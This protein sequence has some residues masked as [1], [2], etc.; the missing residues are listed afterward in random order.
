MNLVKEILY[1]NNGKRTTMPNLAIGNQQIAE[2]AA[3][4][5]AGLLPPGIDAIANGLP[6][7]GPT[8]WTNTAW[9]TRPGP[10]K[11]WVAQSTVDVIVP[12]RSPDGSYV[13]KPFTPG[14]GLDFS[15]WSRAQ[16]DF[17]NS[18]YG[19]FFPALPV[20]VKIFFNSDQAR[21]A[22]YDPGPSVDYPLG[23]VSGSGNGMSPLMAIR[24][25]DNGD[26]KLFNMAEF[27]EANPIVGEQAHVIPVPVSGL[28]NAMLLSA[29]ANI[30]TTSSMPE[31]MRINTIKGMLGVPVPLG[32]VQTPAI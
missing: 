29:I 8:A 23:L 17:Y 30:A 25:D 20:L 14:T 21:D 6:L 5:L 7:F 28:S 3:Y 31:D 2:L 13:L 16:A 11:T 27:R 10:R 19:N 4:K 18:S 22:R 1:P 24:V 15:N 26:L 12:L 32:A 9:L